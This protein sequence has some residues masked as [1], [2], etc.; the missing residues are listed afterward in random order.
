MKKL[1]ILMIHAVSS[2]FKFNSLRACRFYPTCSHYS[3]EA[4]DAFSFPKAMWLMFSRI[5]RCHPFSSG[6]YDPIPIKKRAA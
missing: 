6:G 4:F 5:A 3:V 1:A 2:L